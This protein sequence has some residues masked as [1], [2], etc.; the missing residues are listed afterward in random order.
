MARIRLRKRG[1]I[2]ERAVELGHAILA[3]LE[4][5]ETGGAAD[6]RTVDIIWQAE[7]LGT[8]LWAL[9]LGELESYDQPFDPEWVAWTPV[10]DGELRPREEIALAQ[11]TSRLWHWRA[12]TARLM[13]ESG[14]KLPEQ[15]RSFEQLVAAIAMRGSNEGLLPPPV[16][17]DFPAFGLP[18][19]ELPPP[20]RAEALSI[21]YERH[22]ALNWLCGEGTS[23]ADTPTDT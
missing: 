9:G 1:E 3:A 18:Y 12:R 4:Q 21:A 17:G 19:R 11:E 14:A 5:L 15:W 23:W 2:V 20:R 8:L 13:A 16:R 7:G 6:Q 10:E 22:R